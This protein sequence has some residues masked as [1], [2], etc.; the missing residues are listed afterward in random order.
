MV[1]SEC[2]FV[3]LCEC[4]CVRV[5]KNVHFVYFLLTKIQQDLN[6]IPNKL[7]DFLGVILWAFSICDQRTIDDRFLSSARAAAMFQILV[8]P[9][10]QF[11]E[12]YWLC[13]SQCL[14]ESPPWVARMYPVAVRVVHRHLVAAGVAGRWRAQ[15]TVVR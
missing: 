8:H 2:V 13:S 7:C 4:V 9:A 5:R 11:R 10:V 14:V 1:A 12:S 15:M 3:C 6:L